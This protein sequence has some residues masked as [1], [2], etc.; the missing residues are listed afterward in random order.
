MRKNSLA[1]AAGLALLIG[2]GVRPALAQIQIGAAGPMSGSNAAFGVQ[3]KEGADLAVANINA[4]GGVLGKR[5]HLIIGDDACDPKQA[6]SVAN[7]FV[8]D[9]VVFVDGHF[10]SSTSI[11]AS[12]IYTQSGVLEI[13]PASTNPDY[14]DKGSWATFRTCGRDDE[15]GV[16]AG[17][18][19]SDHFKNSKI[20][21]LDDNSTYGKGIADQVRLNLKKLGVK[22]AFNA[23]Y[24]AGEKDYSALISRMK[25]DGINF[26]Y[27]GG[28]YTDGGL[29]VRQAAAQGWHPQFMGEDAFVTQQFWQIAGPAGEGMLMTFP[30]D[31]RANPAAA[32]VVKQF[33]AKKINPEGYVL[34]SYAAIQVW[35]EA[36]Q[37]AGTVDP[38]KVAAEIKS[39]GPWQT[40][41]G[42]LSYDK[43][44]DVVHAAYV[45]YKWHNGNYAE[46][47]SM[48]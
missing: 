41:I 1:L 32:A 35:A 8:N 15:Q 11:P 26:V 12:K 33:A 17:K 22:I 43:K 44:G 25:S 21:V 45:V 30:P 6:V 10:C 39:G 5:V 4:H 27:I 13:T 38:M 46:L 3:L 48:H 29:I 23:H 20:A 36:A 18:F 28:Y 19:I 47:K 9:G 40:V 37:K 31:Q 14:T 16:V 42:P 34:Y 7:G 2:M 24:T